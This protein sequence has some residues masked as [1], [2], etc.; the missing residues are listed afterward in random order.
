MPRSLHGAAAALLSWTSITSLPLAPAAAP[1]HCLCTCLLLPL[2]R[3]CELGGTAPPASAPRFCGWHMP[4]LGGCAVVIAQAIPCLGLGGHEGRDWGSCHPHLP[5]AA[6]RRRRRWCMDGLARRAVTHVARVAAVYICQ[7]ERNC[8]NPAAAWKPAGRGH[9][10]QTS[11]Q[12]Q[13][14]TFTTPF[15]TFSTTS[16]LLQV[17]LPHARP[18]P[19]PPGPPT[20]SPHVSRTQHHGC[21]LG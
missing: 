9:R 10:A 11:P 20:L 18:P 12:R 5:A 21:N 14:R 2:P 8:W 19:T 17:A 6:T 16:E 15:V 3:G 4:Q 1:V 13:C 7:M